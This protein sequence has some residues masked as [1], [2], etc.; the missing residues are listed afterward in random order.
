M[1]VATCGSETRERGPLPR[2]QVLR[3]RTEGRFSSEK[4][5]Q[6]EGRHSTVL[7][8]SLPDSMI[9]R[10]KGMISVVSRKLI[11]SCSSVFTNAPKM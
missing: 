6:G 11:T 3:L 4:E 5:P 7:E 9:R 1:K 2:L 8:S 10:H